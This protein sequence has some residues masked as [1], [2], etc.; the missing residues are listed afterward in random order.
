MGT[1][2]S[3]SVPLKKFAHPNT[4]MI[5]TMRIRENCEITI[6]GKSRTDQIIRY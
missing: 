4:F 3:K 2:E 1:V 5:K 6:I